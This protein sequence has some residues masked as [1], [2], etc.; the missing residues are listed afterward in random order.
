MTYSWYYLITY[1][2][3]NNL[4]RLF[5]SHNFSASTINMYD[6]KSCLFLP[7]SLMMCYLM[8]C[9]LMI[10]YLMIC[11]LMICHLMICYCPW[12][13]SLMICYCPWWYSLMICYCPW[14]YSLM[15]CYCLF[16]LHYGFNQTLIRRK[17]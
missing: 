9:Y 13:Y 16:R 5:G 17:T 1:P 2:A 10:C 15:L 14:W 7:Y 6:S 4:F 3:G 11:Y 12:W 8:I